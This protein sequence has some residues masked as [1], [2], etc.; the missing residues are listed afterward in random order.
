MRTAS[1]NRATLL[2]F[3]VLLCGWSL[4]RTV[5]QDSYQPI[6]HES[7]EGAVEAIQNFQV[8]EGFALEQAVA[9]LLEL[10]PRSS[11]AFKKAV[12]GASA[13]FEKMKESWGKS[14]K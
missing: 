9:E 4:A 12:E 11:E 2:G 3:V 5:A 10:N 13:Q 1:G 6:V 8:V 14:R 7:A